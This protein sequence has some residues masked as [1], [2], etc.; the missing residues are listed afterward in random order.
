MEDTKDHEGNCKPLP[1]F[2]SFVVDTLVRQA[3]HARQQA[4]PYNHCSAMLARDIE[5]SHP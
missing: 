1:S 5:E 4:A 2:V 3:P